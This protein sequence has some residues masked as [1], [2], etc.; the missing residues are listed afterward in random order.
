MLSWYHE[1]NTDCVLTGLSMFCLR[2]KSRLCFHLFWR[3]LGFAT[4]EEQVST[5]RAC[6]QSTWTFLRISQTCAGFSLPCS[7]YRAQLHKADLSKWENK[8]WSVDMPRP[9]FLC[10][11][12]LQQRMSPSLHLPIHISWASSCNPHSYR[13]QS[14]CNLIACKLTLTSLSQLTK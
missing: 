10:Q 5:L 3:S 12:C 14:A 8:P 2:R 4:I 7:P 6:S 1:D 11:E 13:P 9:L